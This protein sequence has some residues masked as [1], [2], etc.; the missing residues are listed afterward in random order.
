MNYQLEMYTTTCNA[1]FALVSRKLAA[2]E[3]HVPAWFEENT[4][5]RVLCV[6]L[7]FVVGVLVGYRRGLKDGNELLGSELYRWYRPASTCLCPCVPCPCRYS[8]L[9]GGGGVLLQSPA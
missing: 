9:A 7:T 8:R 4:V 1:S 2:C 6:M 5:E 3:Q